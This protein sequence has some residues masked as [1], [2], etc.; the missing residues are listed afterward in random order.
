MST[1]NGTIGHG[2][3]LGTPGY[4]SPLTVTTAGFV[5]NNGVGSAIYGTTG[6]VVNQ[7]TRVASGASIFGKYFGI[8]IYGNGSAYNSG[9]IIAASN[10]IAIYGIGSVTNSG[11]I[12][13][14]QWG[15]SGR[16]GFLAVSNTAR[17]APSHPTCRIAICT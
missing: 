12:S 3:T 5:S 17:R 16:T 15:V 8:E 7:G 14:Q 10:G 2:V 4:Y 9:A 1:I 13:G 6:T 11:A